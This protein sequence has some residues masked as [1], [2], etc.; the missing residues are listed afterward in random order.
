MHGGALMAA[1]QA[2]GQYLV[3]ARP[4]QRALVVAGVVAGAAA[5]LAV[6]IAT[7]HFVTAVIG[8]IVLFA[9]GSGCVQV[10]RRWILGRARREDGSPEDGS[11]EDGSRITASAENG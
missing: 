10:L 9:V 6:G 7:G 2:L 1:R 8:G 4:W 3:Y 11:P 5:L